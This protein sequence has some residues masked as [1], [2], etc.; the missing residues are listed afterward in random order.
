MK[1]DFLNYTWS[2]L[3]LTR[4]RHGKSP[5]VV[6]PVVCN[7]TQPLSNAD[8]DLAGSNGSESDT[9]M[10]KHTL[11]SEKKYKKPVSAACTRSIASTTGINTYFKNRVKID[12]SKLKLD[13]S[14]LCMEE[15]RLKAVED[16]EKAA[17]QWEKAEL[18]KALVCNP[19]SSAALIDVANDYLIKIFQS[20]L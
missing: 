12:E 9:A 8:D 1:G 15:K 5:K 4:Q 13:E 18:A 20:D 3:N 17:A 16:R 19:Q 7:S 10:K 14:R 2:N 6:C 11:V